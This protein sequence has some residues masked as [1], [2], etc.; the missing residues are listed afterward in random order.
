MK[1]AKLTTMIG[2]V[3]KIDLPHLSLFNISAKIDTGAYSCVIQLL[4]PNHPL[5]NDKIFEIEEFTQRVIKNTSGVGE[6]RFVIKSKICIFGKTSDIHFALADRKKM[7]YPILLG[8]KFLAKNKLI[9]D[10]SKRN[11]SYKLKSK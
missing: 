6:S 1:K 10:V 3:D 5:Y 9:V 8:R 4:D 7:G 2:R 11:L